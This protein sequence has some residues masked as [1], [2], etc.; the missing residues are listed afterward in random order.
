MNACLNRSVTS[1]PNRVTRITQLTVS[2]SCLC[3][4]TVPALSADG[5]GSGQVAEVADA[6]P[7]VVRLA[8]VPNSPS[9]RT[10][11]SSNI[12]DA[13]EKLE[14]IVVTAQRREQRLQDVPIA[15]T[16]LGGEALDSSTFTSFTDALRTI[17]GI[18]STND[19][20]TGGNMIS[21]RGVS[22][23][24]A[25]GGG[26]GPVA[27]Y[28]DGTPYGFVRSAIVPG[29]GSL[30]DLE[31]FEF[32]A[33]PQGT[34][35]GA[36]ALNGV[37]RV[38][39]RDPD[40]NA[41]E[42]KGRASGSTTEGGG[43]NYGADAVLNVPLI[44]GKLALRG[45]AGYQD[46]S[47]WI[48]APDERNINDAKSRNYRL[49]VK[50][51]PTD[52]LSMRL[53]VWRTE[54]E[55]GGPNL[56][57][58]DG[59]IT[60]VE[61]QPLTQEFTV[62]AGEVTKS[63]SSFSISSMTSYLEFE[64]TGIVSGEPLPYPVTLPTVVN[65]KV[66][67]EELNLIS[68]LQGP[69]RWSAG[70]FYREAEDSYYQNLVAID[71][72]WGE[73]NLGATELL[74]D[75][76]TD[77]SKSWAVYGELGRSFLNDRLDLGVGLRY[78]RDKQSLRLNSQYYDPPLLGSPFEATS[79]AVTPRVVVTWKHS[80]ETTL[81]ASYAQGFRSG[82][83]QVPDVQVRY[84]NFTPVK[85]DK[86][87]NYEIG[88]KGSLAAGAVSYTAA[89]LY[90][91]WRD[92]QQSL[93]V[94]LPNNLTTGAVVNAESA[95]GL[96]AEFSIAT[97]PIDGLNLGMTLSWNDLTF[98]SDVISGGDVLFSKGDRL[99][100]SPK[101]TVGGFAEYSLPLGEKFMVHASW[102]GDY[103]ATQKNLE[104]GEQIFTSD[105]IFVQHARVSLEF[106]EYWT[107]SLY[108]DNLNNETGSPTPNLGG[109]PEWSVRLQPRTIGVMFDYHF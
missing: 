9:T 102:G 6:P 14:E 33:G 73:E 105:T 55:M 1:V 78:F 38:L 48:D 35:Y 18:T 51:Q 67:S 100:L 96:G 63:F 16:V 68:E 29:G 28:I 77:S 86:L 106:I 72:A 2:I 37:L 89:I 109:I 62:Y 21:V 79:D 58:D 94:T 69:W 80:A 84:P 98:D 12:E 15:I 61:D 56:A 39:T 23:A 91:D 103:K 54:D 20:A 31:R 88:A 27:Y 4:L 19:P 70:A 22:N 11:A 108:A 53:S 49:K 25:R 83:A 26:A 82:F 59:R 3:G 50:A 24:R 34:L 44:D 45:V 46:D 92:I 17:P 8:Q 74:Q 41:F 32:L 71:P 10:F 5:G 36:N 65:A 7:R 95:S 104:T 93:T 101:Y 76:Y 52:T 47:G 57:N 42:F 40:L 13:D 64:G 60:A 85:P 81:Y 97:R 75:D 107:A 43:E 87:T 30:Y 99:L 66:F 90:I